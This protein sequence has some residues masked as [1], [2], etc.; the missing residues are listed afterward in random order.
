MNGRAKLRAGDW[1]EIRSKE[2][3]LRTL[4]KQGQLEALPLMPEMLQYCGQRFQIFKQAHKTCDPPS[5]LQ[6]RRMT[7][8]VHL[9]GVR[10]DGSAHGGCQAGCLIF[11]KEAW[12]RKVDANDPE[13]QGTAAAEPA[14]APLVGEG[15]QCTE[16]DVVAAVHQASDT[17]RV[18]SPAYSCQSTRLYAAT[19]PLFWWDLRQYVEDLTSGNVRPSQMIAAALF[20]LYQSVA[21]AGLGLG[22][23]MRWAY[24][25][26][27]KFRGGAPYPL[28]PGKISKD[29][30]TPS[31]TLD[32]QPGE[33]VRVRSYPEILATLDQD[34]HN[35]GMY[36][37]GE[38]V[39][40]CNGTYQVL[41]RVERIID[42]KT[43]AMRRLKNDAII[44]SE[45]ACQARYA[46]CRRFCSRSIY[47]YW[48]EIWLERVEQLDRTSP[49]ALPR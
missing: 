8:S 28:R 9:T 22:S 40:F 49:P 11:W 21:E 37:D 23:A 41:R 46:K 26:F 45:V 35:R 36:F 1:V 15:T 17:A 27:Q 7:K 47:P 19:T 12:L 2:E 33:L 10:C 34:W 4:D 25:T 42:E 5:G 44:L 20:F 31:A 6:A 30:R 32:L 16:E 24:D 13:S 29:M 14:A 43:G 38:Q 18:Q 48:R 39:P 3:I